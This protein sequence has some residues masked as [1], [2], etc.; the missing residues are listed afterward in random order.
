MQQPILFRQ[1]FDPPPSLQAGATKAVVFDLGGV[2]IDLHSDEAGRELIEQ[3]G[4]SPH[5]FARLTRSCFE[6]HPR[7]VTELA[8]L[9]KI[10]T[11]TYLEAFLRECSVK[12]PERL[13][14]NRLSVVGRERKDVLTIV[15]HL[16]QAGLKCCVLSNT[17]ALH[18]ERLGSVR[19]HPWLALFDHIFASHLIGCAKPEKEAFS[20]VANALKVQMWECLLVDDTPLNIKSAK[21]LGWG[22]ILFTSTAQ[23]QRDVSNLLQAPETSSQSLESTVAAVPNPLPKPTTYP[24]SVKGVLVV[25]GRV[26][27]VKNSRDEWELPGG[28]PEEGEEHAQTLAREFMEELSIKISMSAPL[29][30]YLFEVIPGR[31]VFIVTYGCELIGE[32]QPVVSEEHDEYC[33]WPV[34]RISELNLPEMYKRSIEK[35]S[36][37]T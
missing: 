10:E 11:S 20:F 13:R 21:A 33:M 34:N 2:L 25:E 12:N 32:F 15:Q 35:W 28:R 14:A 36:D 19:E 1:M 30:S 29:D 6:S 7:S 26:L 8:M 16:K 18:W 17:I 4:L 5:S 23:L 3:Y 9:G 31:H 27:L 37:A 22:G 24:T